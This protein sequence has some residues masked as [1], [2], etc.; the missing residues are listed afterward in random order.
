MIWKSDILLT[1]LIVKIWF[2]RVIYYWRP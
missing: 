2:G 1:T